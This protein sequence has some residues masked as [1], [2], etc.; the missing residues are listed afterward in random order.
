[1]PIDDSICDIPGLKIGH[2]TSTQRP[3]GCSV[4]LCEQGAVA[5]VDVR[6]AA[7]GT[8]E[9]DLLAPENT[10]DRVHAL[11]LAGGSAFGLDAAGG[12]MRWLAERGHGFPV[13]PARVPIVPGAVIFDLWLGDPAITPDAA[14]GYAAC[15]AASTAP[16]AEGN[17]GAGAGATIGKLLGIARAMKGGIGSASLTVG[18]V[19]LGALVVVNAIGDIIDPASGVLLAGAR[20]ADGRPLGM[21]AALQRGELPQV[22]LAGTAT[23]LGIVATNARL[24]KAA[25]TKLAQMAHDGLA[26]CI[27]PVHT[28]SDGDVIF[29]L[30]TGGAETPAGDLRLLGPLAA[31]VTARAV[32][33]AVR[34]ARGLPGLPSI[35]ELP[36]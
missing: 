33:R 17:V 19:T 26:R 11:L 12:V 15:E 14:A 22:P 7:P 13:G 9:T 24:D 18:G 23:T 35:H 28:V 25:A 6:G 36:G 4:L 34:A 10:V 20:G 1:M 16:P 5:G 32:L 31:E 2:W 30:A 29:A 21:I 8:R 27:N 3:T